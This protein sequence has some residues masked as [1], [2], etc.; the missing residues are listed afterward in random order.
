MFALAAPFAAAAA[1]VSTA[2]VAA[3]AR[4][5]HEAQC[6]YKQLTWDDF[7]GP[8][9]QGTHAA[10][11]SATIVIEP[12]LVDMELA[13]GGGAV[14]RARNPVV[15]AMM[16]K[17][18]SGA[19]RGG[20]STTSLAHEQTHFDL[21]EY[22]ARRLWRELRALE[23][24]GDEPSESLQRKLMLEIERLYNVAMLDLDRLNEQF[25]RETLHRV[26]ALRKWQLRAAELLASEE[27]YVLR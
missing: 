3:A 2:P 5:D 15:Y 22:M 21:T 25:D 6:T 1:L 12:T 24:T 4:I 23:V 26:R 18:E 19:Q 9:V 27:P 8:I 14:A 13:P 11:I 20:R 16:N 10:W 17:L 7:R